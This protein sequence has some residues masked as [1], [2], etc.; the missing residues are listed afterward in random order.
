M[1]R[2]SGDYQ[3][4]RRFPDSFLN[5][6]LQRVFGRFWEAIAKTHQ[7]WWDTESTIS[8]VA[9]QQYVAL[10]A[11]C[12]R[13]QG[14]DLLES[15]EYESLLQVGLGDRNRYGAQQDRP[16]AYRTSSRGAELYPTPNAIYTLRVNYT[17]KATALDD[18]T[19]REWYNGWEEFMIEGAKLEIARRERMPLKDHYDAL[20]ECFARITEGASE[21]RSQEPEYLKLREYDTL[22]LYEDGLL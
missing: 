7:G 10:P 13:V 20:N 4:V 6:I 21:R 3:N 8:T 11:D 14:I 19:S 22:D 9:A 16:R 12:W 2:N 17:P 5:E 1:I 18:A 15:G